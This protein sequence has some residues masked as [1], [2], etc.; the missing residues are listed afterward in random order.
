MNTNGTHHEATEEQI[1]RL[2]AFW[3]GA[4]PPPAPLPEAAFSLTLKG[5]L[6]GVDALLTVRG[7]T[8]EQFQRNLQAIRGLLDQVAVQS[9]STGAETEPQAA[10]ALPR[11]PDH[12]FLRKGKRGNYYCPVKRADGSYC[13]FTTKQG[14]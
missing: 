12:G 4:T 11:C 6:A 1:D 3:P 9:Q 8:P 13:D 5:H 2:Y 14:H 10:E 7:Q